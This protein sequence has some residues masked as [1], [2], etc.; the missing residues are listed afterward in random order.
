MDATPHADLAIGLSIRADMESFS[1]N[2]MWMP[3]YIKGS[4][5]GLRLCFKLRKY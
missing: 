2:Y 3:K 5:T 1:M 4:M